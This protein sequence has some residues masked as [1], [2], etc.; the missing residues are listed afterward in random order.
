MRF[1]RFFIL[2]MVIALLAGL[3]GGVSAQDGVT[4]VLWHALQ[5][6]EADGAL[7]IIDAFHEANPDITIEPV[8]SPRRQ[9]RIA[10][11]PPLAGAKARILWCGPTIQ[12]A[13]GH[14]Q[15]CCSI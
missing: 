3:M 4:L 13:I 12:L 14:G 5:D 9:F 2:G 15:I 11:W 8:F 6:A 7:A 10:L 1:S